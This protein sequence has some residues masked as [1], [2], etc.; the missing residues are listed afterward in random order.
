MAKV[1]A[2]PEVINNLIL[3]K[4]FWSRSVLQIDLSQLN[5]D[6]W[7]KEKQPQNWE[8]VYSGQNTQAFSVW[9]R[10]SIYIALVNTTGTFMW[11]EVR[12]VIENEFSCG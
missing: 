11:A 1:N 4:V 10:R 7:V 8:V 12:N 3:E 5:E 6:S 9:E 2:F